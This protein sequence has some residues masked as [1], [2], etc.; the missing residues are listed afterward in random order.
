MRL[1]LGMPTLIEYDDLKSNFELC[2]ELGLDFVEVNLNLPYC[3]PST[4][5][6][7]ANTNQSLLE[8][9]E[10]TIHLPEE[11]DISNFH[12]LIR[13]GFLRFIKQMTEIANQIGARILNLHLRRGVY[14]TLP[15]KKVWVN[16]K[17]MDRSIKQFNAA[18]VEID[19]WA[20]RSGCKI[21]FENEGMND[22]V[23]ACVQE[24]NKY[25][26]LFLTWDVGH[27]SAD[28]FR[29]TSVME[30]NPLKVAHMHLHD[31]EWE[32]KPQATIHWRIEH[33][34]I[35][36]LCDQSWIECRCRSQNE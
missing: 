24:L 16:E 35:F 2:N 22:F 19:E 9:K 11:T 27:D 26:N 33:Q 12:Y 21:C 1:R 8:G 14:F 17:N 30:Q 4:L 15:D 10:I 7:F 34:K 6:E 20:N 25:E 23:L 32:Q 28:G 36:G 5:L 31:G 18:L 29:A 13:N 3:E